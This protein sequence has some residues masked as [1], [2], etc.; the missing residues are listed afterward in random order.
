M[1]Y[2]VLMPDDFQTAVDRLNF[3]QQEDAENTYISPFLCFA[4]LAESRLSRE[5][6]VDIKTDLLILCDGLLFFD[7]ISNE[8]RELLMMAEKVGMPIEQV[9]I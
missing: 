3:L 4:H 5:Q 8:E 6:I 2:C 7:N 9:K 1:T